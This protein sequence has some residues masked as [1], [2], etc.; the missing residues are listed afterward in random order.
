MLEECKLPERKLPERKLCWG[1]YFIGYIICEIELGRYPS[2]S[3]AQLRVPR[4]F[5]IPTKLRNG[6]DTRKLATWLEAE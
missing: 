4:P 1:S 5:Q 6:A 3:K 2:M